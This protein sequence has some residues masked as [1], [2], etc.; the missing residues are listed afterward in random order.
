MDH[1]NLYDE[2][3]RLLFQEKNPDLAWEYLERSLALDY[4][5]EY[6]SDTL[7]SLG[8]AASHNNANEENKSCR[9]AEK[10]Y[11]KLTEL[12][13]SSHAND[14]LGRLYRFGGNDAP[15]ELK[16]AAKHFQIAVDEAEYRPT[17]FAFY[18]LGLCYGEGI[19]IERDYEK[20]FQ[21][22]KLAA[23]KGNIPALYSC[24]YCYKHGRGV[25]KDHQKAME[26]YNKA[27]ESYR[28]EFGK[29]YQICE[30]AIAWLQI[31]SDDP[32][33]IDV[34]AARKTYQRM[35][36]EGK[37]IENAYLQLGLIYE[38]GRGNVEV[39]REKALPYFLKAAENNCMD[40]YTW[41]GNH[42]RDGVGMP[43]DLVYAEECFKKSKAFKAARECA[44]TIFDTLNIQDKKKMAVNRFKNKE[45]ILS[46]TM[47]ES[48]AAIDGNAAFIAGYQYEYGLGIEEDYIKAENLYKHAVKL[49]SKEA[50]KAL[51]YFN[52][53]IVCPHCGTVIQRNKDYC[54]CTSCGVKFNAFEQDTEQHK[55][56]IRKLN[57]A[58]Y[59]RQKKEYVKAMEITQDLLNEVDIP[60]IR[61]SHV[62][63]RFGI[64]YYCFPIG[65]HID[66]MNRDSILFDHESLKLFSNNGL[67]FLPFAALLEEKLQADIILS[68]QVGCMLHKKLFICCHKDEFNAQSYA[69]SLLIN[70]IQ[71][72]YNWED[73]ESSF[74]REVVLFNS[75]HNAAAVVVIASDNQFA[76]DPMIT[77]I[78]NIANIINNSKGECPVVGVAL[79]NTC[80]EAFKSYE[81][82]TVM[83]LPKEKKALDVFLHEIVR[84]PNSNYLTRILLKKCKGNNT[85]ESYNTIRSY[86]NLPNTIVYNNPSISS[87]IISPIRNEVQL[88]GSII[89]LAVDDHFSYQLQ[90]KTHV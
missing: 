24:G 51:S 29:N 61:W 74:D 23:E 48:L 70:G 1:K 46:L 64:R 26:C 31:H 19:G 76:K 10:Y 38:L 45:Y 88:D 79:S 55:R 75:I 80:H 30:T 34:E 49:G 53:D 72:T 39:N 47:L 6:W 3:C 66:M 17:S 57:L 84:W 2:G 16:K 41:I 83:L 20:A 56:I 13:Y 52:Q 28:K 85:L 78:V 81:V 69:K 12:F 65:F 43:K 37:M 7:F 77:S 27:M 54:Q 87:F 71:K 9:L 50:E 15:I 36:E 59:L 68:D 67:A 4:N 14:K 42:A 44:M 5:K 60:I 35:I 73:C 11:E 62:L 21:L 90:Y 63:A 25:E 89:D 33:L 32:T 22:F 58:N 18:D 86:Y 40:A 82:D 8:V